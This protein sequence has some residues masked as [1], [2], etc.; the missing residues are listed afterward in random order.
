MIYILKP[1]RSK[2][3]VIH[4]IKRLETFIDFIPFYQPI[5]QALAHS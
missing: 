5:L 3:P 4:S 2:E 1:F